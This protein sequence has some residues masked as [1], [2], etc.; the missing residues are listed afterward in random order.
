MPPC[1]TSS[2]PNI[3]PDSCFSPGN[4]SPTALLV[5]LF[6]IHQH[7]SLLSRCSP[8]TPHSPGVGVWYFGNSELSG[9]SPFPDAIKH[10]PR[11]LIPI[12][13]LSPVHFRYHPHF[14]PALLLPCSA[15]SGSFQASSDRQAGRASP[16][17]WPACALNG[18]RSPFTSSPGAS[19]GRPEG[20]MSTHA[21]KW[22]HCPNYMDLLSRQCPNTKLGGRISGRRNPAARPNLWP[23][24]YGRGSQDNH[25]T[26]FGWASEGG[27]CDSH[28]GCSVTPLTAL[29]VTASI[30]N[31][32]PFS[33]KGGI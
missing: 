18:G 27:G 5:R 4:S 33:C 31:L 13:L 2:Q 32:A 20:A 24:L 6:L 22:W 8:K 26:Q 7:P 15:S 16:W 29:A 17:P 9:P 10:P 3:C 30:Y 25:Q 21:Q 19:Q 11:M 28:S 1:L 12:L 23:V 14:S